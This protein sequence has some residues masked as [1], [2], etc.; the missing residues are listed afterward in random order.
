MRPDRRGGVPFALL[1]VALLLGSVAL[2]AA[3]EERAGTADRIDGITEGEDAFSRAAEGVSEHVGRGL[4]EIIL[5]VST[6]AT[7]GGVDG[8]IAEFSSRASDWM[9]FQFPLSDSGIRVELRGFDLPLSVENM[10]ATTG[11]WTVD[12]Y[13]PAYLK[14]TGTVEVRMVSGLGVAEC[15]V[16]IETDGSYGL[17]LT[18]ERGSLFSAMAGGIPLVQ[19]VEYQLTALAQQRVLN[20][21]GS[22]DAYGDRGTSAV[23]TADDV[24]RAYDASL[25]AVGLLC[26]RDAGDNGTVTG[27]SDLADVLLA[28][29]DGYVE[30]DLTALHAQAIA[31]SVDDTVGRW[32]EYLCGRDALGLLEGRL[33]SYELAFGA[34]ASFLRGDGLFTAAPYI[35]RVM[36]S[37]G[38]PETVYRTPG[39]GTTSGTVGGIRISVEN[40]TADMFDRH[41]I[42]KFRSEHVS[43]DDYLA[44]CISSVLNS[45]ALRVASDDGM[46]TV[47]FAVDP[48]D[49]TAFHTALVD[50]L[51]ACLEGSEATVARAIGDA[52][53]GLRAVDPFYA[54]ISA[55]VAE[56]ADEMVLEDE[57]RSRVRSALLSSAPE[58]TDVDALMASPQVDAMVHSY[59][60]AVMSDLGAYSALGEVPGGGSVIVREALAAIASSPL[61]MLDIVGDMGERMRGLV[62]EA[63]LAMASNP[64]AGP[65]DLPDSE[66]FRISD[67]T[68]NGTVERISA[69]IS[70]DPVVGTPHV[71][72]GCIHSTGT[73]GP[74]GAAYTTV[75]RVTVDDLVGFSLEG[76]GALSQAL[77]TVTSAV[78]GTARVSIDLDIA[79]VSGWALSGVRYSPDATV[80]DDALAAALE[81]LGPVLEPLMEVMGVLRDLVTALAESLVDIGRQVAS[82]LVGIYEDVMGPVMRINEWVAGNLESLVSGTVLDVLFSIGLDEQTV[83]V[84]HMG[85]TLTLETDAVSLN[86]STKTLLTATVSGPVGDLDASAGITVR[87]RGDLEPE[88]L[89]VTGSGNV[90]GDGWEVDMRLDPLMK[91]GRHLLA[92][93]CDVDGTDVSVRI[94]ELDDYHELGV[95]L[96]DIPGIGDV[97]DSLPSPVPGTRLS[98]DA[99]FTLR[100]SRPVAEGLII[101]EFESNPPGDDGTGEWVEILNNTSSGID[102][103]GYTLC[104]SSDWRRKTMPLSGELDPG[105]RLVVEPDFVLVNSSG[106]YTKNGEALS[107][108]D[109]EGETVDRTP[110][111][112]DG[113]NDGKSWHRRFDGST[114]W[115]FGDA[116]RDGPNSDSPLE[117]I[118]P[119]ADLKNLV[120]NAVEDAFGDVGTITDLD[121]LERFTESLVEHTL[122]R[123]ID[124]VSGSI[125]EASVFVSADVVDVTGSA[126][127]GVRIA[128]RADGSLAGD[129][130]RYVAGHLQELVLGV[131]NPYSI[132]PLAMFTEN[133]GLEVTVHTGLGFPEFLAEEPG[134]LPDMDLGVTF[135]ANLASLT[136]LVG[137][138]TGGPGLFC[139]IRAMDC[140]VAAVPG[141]LNPS[142]DMDHDLWLMTVSVTYPA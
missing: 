98:L 115:V 54:A 64:H 91:G 2:A 133:I 122:D 62:S 108:K 36:A 102:L 50:A 14:C 46:G 118:L 121:S 140:P 100:Y 52:A 27:D 56:H 104:A 3:V 31:A 135:R 68:G 106:K 60:S 92:L 38:V 29:D 43:G 78:D 24:R 12:G 40:P 17:P 141:R 85:Y 45:A 49:G 120:W 82:V 130:L 11:D 26:F 107:I 20:G 125:V 5:S 39:S 55:T 90:E 84:G 76:S 142:A 65:E 77:G 136:D 34:L 80:L 75:F 48:G 113:A 32:T 89:V 13:V 53:D 96:G 51:D 132:D 111:L 67:G 30:L 16:D 137:E 8:R 28:G 41:W 74:T 47:G 71:S 109:P 25:R 35:E 117:N 6:D 37:N 1:A 139:G 93:D 114:E 72:D 105:E 88:N 95:T 69:V 57:F 101:N 42:A 110:T 103:D 59:R 70:S 112:A 10:S 97:L 18:A 86:A 7:L 128:L 79:V 123:L 126:E 73:R 81:V 131:D 58:G 127:T 33:D 119:A 94:P 44:G 124:R 116:S 61:E 99:G 15:T 129:V 4:G 21:Y 66:G 138:D 23:L 87:C 83:T 134:N 22:L 63:A 9:G 19:M